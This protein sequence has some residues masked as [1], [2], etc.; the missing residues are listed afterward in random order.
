[1]KDKQ[2]NCTQC[3]SYQ[4]SPDEEQDDCGIW[5]RCGPW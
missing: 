1:M 2:L 4:F 5:R 3:S